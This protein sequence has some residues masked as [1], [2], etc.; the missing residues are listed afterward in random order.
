MTHNVGAKL[1]T[2]ATKITGARKT[3]D[4]YTVETMGHYDMKPAPNG[5]WVMYEDAQA[6][7]DAAVAEERE[8]W[9]YALRCAMAGMRGLEELTHRVY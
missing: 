4:R 3:M 8:Q 2:T 7:I 1:E 5:M 6:A 9:E